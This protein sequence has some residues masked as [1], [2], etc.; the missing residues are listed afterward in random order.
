M[1]HYTGY[2]TLPI[3]SY[4][5][6][7][8]AVNNN[9]YDVDGYPPDQ[10]FQCWDLTAEFWW[11]AGFPQGYPTLA[12]TGSAYG[13]WTD[14][15]QNAGDQFDLINNVSDIKVGDVIVFNY[16]VG[17]PYGHI[18][19][20]DEDYNGTNT[21]SILSQN[22]GAFYTNIANYSL[23]HFR[24]AFRYKAWHTT[25]PTPPTPT[26]ARKRFPWVLYTRKLNEKRGGM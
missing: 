19:F 23:A 1:A 11:N 17:N 22:N 26:D 20:A 21:I 18:G 25:P 5:S 3:N 12:G 15:I 10:P 4:A 2:V 16:F 13:A 14:K 8:T 24:G 6:W 7:R 9:G